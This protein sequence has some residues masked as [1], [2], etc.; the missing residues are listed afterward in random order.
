MQLN[1]TA[2]ST[3]MHPH[4][5]APNRPRGGWGRDGER[6]VYDYYYYYSFTEVYESRASSPRRERGSVPRARIFP[7]TVEAGHVIAP[8]PQKSVF[9]SLAADVGH[10]QKC[11]RRA[12]TNVR[13]KIKEYT[14]CEQSRTSVTLL[15]PCLLYTSPSPRDRQKS[16]MPSSA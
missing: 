15:D 14:K 6:K 12:R 11:S 7:P 16:R 2:H 8:L 1:L 13:R 3:S 10:T 9:H 4:G 5:P